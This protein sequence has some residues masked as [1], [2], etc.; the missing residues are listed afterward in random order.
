MGVQN[1][2]YFNPTANINWNDAGH[3]QQDFTDYPYDYGGLHWTGQSDGIDLFARETGLDNLDLILRFSDDGSNKLQ[4]QN[5]T[6]GCVAEI[7]ADGHISSAGEIYRIGQPVASIGTRTSVAST[8]ITVSASSSEITFTGKSHNHSASDSGHTH[9]YSKT[10]SASFTGTSHNHSASDSGHTHT[11]DFGTKGVSVS[12]AA[13]GVTDYYY[14][15][16]TGSASFNGNSHS[17]NITDKS[18]SHSYTKVTGGSFTGTKDLKTGSSGTGI[19][20]SASAPTFTGTAHGHGI[21]DNGHAHSAHINNG[22]VQV[23]APA[24][25]STSYYYITSSGATST[26][27]GDSHSHGVTDNGHTHTYDKATSITSTGGNHSHTYQRTTVSY[28]KDSKTLI[29]KTT[30]S[31]TTGTS[32][33][34]S[35]AAS[36]IGY[37]ATATT[38]SKTGLSINGTTAGGSVSTTVYD[39]QMGVRN[40]DK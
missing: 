33:N 31:A 21:G 3:F 9:T 14:I 35:V 32:G 13:D 26:F 37:T 8:G 34:L 38:S 25:G 16:T 22:T 12:K 27:T 1:G 2:F 28:D 5:Q 11:V 6:G 23:T 30:E 29:I 10:T 15:K 24:T 4:V 39:P 40:G 7:G 19:T 17:H 18:H 36:S 20:A